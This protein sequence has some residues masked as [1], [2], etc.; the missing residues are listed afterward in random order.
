MSQPRQIVPPPGN[1]MHGPFIMVAVFFPAVMVGFAW[2]VAAS[3]VPL[4]SAMGILYLLGLVGIFSI[5]T[6]AWSGRRIEQERSHLSSP[7]VVAAW[8]LTKHEYLRFVRAEWRHQTAW[9]AGAFAFGIGTPLLFSLEARDLRFTAL[10]AGCG[11]VVVLMLL[12][13]EMPP[14]RTNART[15]DVRIGTEGIEVM[16]RYHQMDACVIRPLGKG[17]LGNCADALSARGP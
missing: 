4:G 16:G 8:R 5:G 11:L 2:Y 14:L 7:D 1:P 13:A 10:N 12:L 9:L 3:G 15:R 6:V 17:R